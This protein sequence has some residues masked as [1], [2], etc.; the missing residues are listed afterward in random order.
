M[1][2]S[3]AFIAMIVLLFSLTACNSS[4]KESA[5]HSEE[6]KMEYNLDTKEFSPVM[7][8]FG[9]KEEL[10]AYAFAAEHPEVLDYMP[11]Y[12]GCY[13]SDGHTNNTACFI[14]SINGN[15]AILDNMGLG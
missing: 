7:T 3:I 6:I 8:Q 4:E 14:D 2:K 5:Q 11:C 1:H 9:S 13:E 12:C 10:E 15:V